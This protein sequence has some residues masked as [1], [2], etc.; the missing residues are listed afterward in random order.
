VVLRVSSGNWRLGRYFKECR[1]DGMGIGLVRIYDS[2]IAF[3]AKAFIT[4]V[5]VTVAA[6]NFLG[7]NIFG[8]GTFH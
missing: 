1:Q 4:Y 2:A 6:P 8:T 7:G 5:R 3:C